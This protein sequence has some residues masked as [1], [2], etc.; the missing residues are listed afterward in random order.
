MW[1]GGNSDLNRLSPDLNEFIFGLNNFTLNLN[2]FK[3]DLNVFGP[4]LNRFI[5]QLNEFKPGPNQFRFA[6]NTFKSD[7]NPFKSEADRFKSGMNT[8][9]ACPNFCVSLSEFLCLRHNVVPERN[10]YAKSGMNTLPPAG[11][12]F[13][14]GLNVPFP[15]P[16]KS[17]P[18]QGA[19]P[20]ILDTI[21]LP[22]R[23]YPRRRDCLLPELLK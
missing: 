20:L 11:S 17:V 4:D 15:Y 21:F 3:V 19:A 9:R 12:R 1:A 13:I 10:G 14:P 22:P 2:R 16:G 18:V 6:L 8:L 7:M 5:F 23:P